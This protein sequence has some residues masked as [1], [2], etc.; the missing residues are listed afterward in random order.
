MQ[1]GRA[2]K[3][4]GRD[5]DRYGEQRKESRCGLWA[6]TAESPRLF[7]LLHHIVNPRHFL[8]SHAQRDRSAKRQ[9]RGQWQRK[10][11][12]ERRETSRNENAMRGDS[13]LF[14]LYLSQFSPLSWHHLERP[15][16]R[17]SLPSPTSMGLG[18]LHKDYINHE[19]TRN[20]SC[21]QDTFTLSS[22]SFIAGHPLMFFLWL[23]QRKPSGIW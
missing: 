13:Q 11:K 5:V 17:L 14:V 1:E 20:L 2:N 16:R 15:W 21:S 6:E 4:S 10:I 23:S 22:C 8:W 19:H 3:G 12:K 7:S 9:H 18:L